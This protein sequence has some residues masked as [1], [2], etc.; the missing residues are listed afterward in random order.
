MKE[1]APILHPFPRNDEIP[2][3]I[4]NDPRAMYFR[5]ARNGMWIRAALLAHIFNV[6]TKVMSHHAKVFSEY[7]DYNAGAV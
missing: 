3:E 2:F 1:Y 4:D 7:H 5:Q 6:D